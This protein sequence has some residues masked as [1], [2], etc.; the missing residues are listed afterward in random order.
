MTVFDTSYPDN[1]IDVKQTNKVC[2]EIVSSEFEINFHTGKCVF[3]W[4]LK[5]TFIHI[6]LFES[7]KNKL[8]NTEFSLPRETKLA[9]GG[10]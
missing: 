1:S 7:L 5:Q 3:L 4:S 9:A 8:P 2:A 10:I 6:N